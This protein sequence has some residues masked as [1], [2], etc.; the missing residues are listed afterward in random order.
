MQE[1]LSVAADKHRR[2]M[3]P[4]CG[5]E[6]VIRLLRRLDP[7]D[8]S[9]IDDSLPCSRDRGKQRRGTR[10]VRPGN[11]LAPLPDPVV[12]DGADQVGWHSVEKCRLI[13]Q[14]VAN[15]GIAPIKQRQGITA[16]SKIAWMEI[17]VDK[18][19]VET[20]GV[21]RGKS[22]RK[23]AKKSFEHLM[24]VD[25]QVV[26][27]PIK[28]VAYQRTESAPPPVRQSQTNQLLSASD[29]RSLNPDEKRHH[30]DKLV[31][32]G[33]VQVLPMDL[34]EQ[35]AATVMAKDPGYPLPR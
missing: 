25:R 32:V 3:Q 24:V 11:Y 31:L 35:D 19:V 14:G 22:L 13:Q 29:P 12:S 1:N 5:I 34:R 23:V 15:A 4:F 28:H 10:R 16:S 27:G 7:V 18:R 6:A 17:A 26:L 20:A 30:R 8:E 21:N 2:P 9:L 33:F